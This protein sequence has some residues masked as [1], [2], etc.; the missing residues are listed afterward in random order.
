MGRDP[1]VGPRGVLDGAHTF[2]ASHVNV[3]VADRPWP[4]GSLP[5]VTANMYAWVFPLAHVLGST[6]PAATEA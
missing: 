3:A 1:G 6:I 2:L 5:I 4:A